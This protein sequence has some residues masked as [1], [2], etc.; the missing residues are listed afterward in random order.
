MLILG[1][2]PSLSNFGW[3]LH[4]TD[5]AGS[6]LCIDRGRFQTSSKTLFVDRYT[7][8]R[9]KVSDLIQKCNVK[10]IGI[11]YPI[12]N[13]LYSEGMYGLFLYTCE[14]MRSLKTDVVFFSPM[15]V[16]AQARDLKVCSDG[17]C[18]PFRPKGWKMEKPDMVEAAKLDTGE[19]KYWNHNEADA[20]WIARTAGRFW[21]YY[22]SLMEA[23]EDKNKS[24]LSL[25]NLEKKLFTEIHTYSRGEKAGSSNEKGIL[26]HENERFFLWSKEK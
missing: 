17:D 16:K 8:I 18:I 23:F 25:S 11:E 15:Q 5:G 4:D 6:S 2:D 10:R 13:D 3:A 14:A 19:K 9:Q 1:F 26:Y 21:L 20:Y 12:F 24:V 7:D 22:D